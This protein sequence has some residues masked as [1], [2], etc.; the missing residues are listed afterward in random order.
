M[1][2][3]KLRYL[4]SQKEARDTSHPLPLAAPSSFYDKGPVFAWGV[5][6]I[7]E[8]FP[9]VPHPAPFLRI[10]YTPHGLLG[11]SANQAPST[12][13]L[14]QFVFAAKLQAAADRD[15]HSFSYGRFFGYS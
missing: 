9:Q 7:G 14:M 13:F 12:L 10:S 1:A 6:P 2:T 4:L 11:P 15:H 8:L 5:A 3:L